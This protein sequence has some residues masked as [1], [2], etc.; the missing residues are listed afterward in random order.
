VKRLR[1]RALLLG[2]VDTG[3]SSQV[4]TLFTEA[5][6]VVAAI[7][8]GA[9][10]SKRRFAG[11][12]QTF[13]IY[14]VALSERAGADL[15]GLDEAV[16]VATNAGIVE[17]LDRLE[18][19]TRVITIVRALLP[20]HE[21]EP[22]LFADVVAT[23]AA[24]ARGEAGDA[25]LARWQLRALAAAGLEPALDRCA[26][27]G[28]PVPAGRS[29]RF[30]ARRGGVVCRED[31][32]G[33]ILLAAGVLSALGVHDGAFTAKDARE[34]RAALDAFLEEHV[35]SRRQSPSPSRR[36][37]RRPSGA[38]GRRRRSGRSAVG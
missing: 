27:C 37:R 2:R 22:M 36:M 25:E 3:E 4:V 16:L 28:K 14:D 24:I 33:P 35:V 13:A 32:G 19:A 18:R 12:L 1:T 29:A 7:A 21:P 11:G 31:G 20:R 30:D 38:R 17:A 9:R 10:R 23:L 6:G 26:A 5:R 34:A 8:R 15:A